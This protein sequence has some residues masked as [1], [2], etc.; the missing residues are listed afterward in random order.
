M[1]LLVYVN[2]IVLATNN[3]QASKKFKDYLHGCFSIKDL[4]PLK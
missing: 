2:E 1:A 3:V 4:R